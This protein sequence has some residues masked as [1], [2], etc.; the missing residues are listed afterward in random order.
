MTRMQVSFGRHYSGMMEIS[1][2]M[3]GKH[4]TEMTGKL[5]RSKK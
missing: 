3:V 2:K 1:V 5:Y 4:Y